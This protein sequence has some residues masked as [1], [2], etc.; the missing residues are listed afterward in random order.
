[1]KL[2][3]FFMGIFKI[4]LAFQS[5]LYHIIWTLKNAPKVSSTITSFLGVGDEKNLINQKNYI[6]MYTTSI[7]RCLKKNQILVKYFT[8]FQVLELDFL[9]CHKF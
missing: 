6:K 5:N 9:D 8:Y 3:V 4:P 2:L 1:M 7:L